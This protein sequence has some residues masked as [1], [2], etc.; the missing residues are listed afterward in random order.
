MARRIF[1]FNVNNPPPETR[2]YLYNLTTVTTNAEFPQTNGEVWTKWGV[3][4]N[5]Q[6]LM[7]YENLQQGDIILFGHSKVGGY[8]HA[9]EV[10]D[11][12]GGLAPLPGWV[13]AE[14]YRWCF[15]I[16]NLYQLAGTIRSS[17]VKGN[18]HRAVYMRVPEENVPQILNHL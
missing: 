7:V 15:F 8:T 11:R 5:S 9:A 4:D 1:A 17:I 2:D 16:K 3:P 18:N 12:P 14:T 10:A 13:N 6:A